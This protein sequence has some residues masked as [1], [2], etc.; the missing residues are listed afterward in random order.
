MITVK[1]VQVKSILKPNPSITGNRTNP[2]QL[3]VYI[4]TKVLFVANDSRQSD[5]FFAGR[6]AS[7]AF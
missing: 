7:G 2:T 1:M 3:T 5:T 6:C 4:L